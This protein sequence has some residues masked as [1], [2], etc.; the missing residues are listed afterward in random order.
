MHDFFKILSKLEHAQRY[1]L[2]DTQMLAK[3]WYTSQAENCNCY[4]PLLSTIGVKSL[5]AIVQDYAHEGLIT[6]PWIDINNF[7]IYSDVSDARSLCRRTSRVDY[8]MKDTTKPRVVIKICD[9]DVIQGKFHAVICDIHIAQSSASEIKFH[10]LLYLGADELAFL[11]NTTRTIND[12]LK[13]VCGGK[14]ISR[15]T[16]RIFS[17]ACNAIRCELVEILSEIYHQCQ[18]SSSSSLV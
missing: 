2:P 17:D 10:R 8:E 11:W 3:L 9:H 5:V 7:G 1:I 13:L 12:L 16:A 15:A 14:K 6:H 18:K 4:S